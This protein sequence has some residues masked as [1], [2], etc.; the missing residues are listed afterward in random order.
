MESRKTKT[1]GKVKPLGVCQQHVTGVA[2]HYSTRL[3]IQHLPFT[4]YLSLHLKYVEWFGKVSLKERVSFVSL[5]PV[6]QIKIKNRCC[7]QSFTGRAFVRFLSSCRLHMSG[8]I[9]AWCNSDTSLY[10]KKGKKNLGHEK[11]SVRA[12]VL[13]C[14]LATWHC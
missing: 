2:D 13:I 10:D 4:P 14:Y 3:Y 8:K 1:E 9:M 11:L 5:H 6:F 12:A 7:Y